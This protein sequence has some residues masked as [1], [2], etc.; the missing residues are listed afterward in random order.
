MREH[1]IGDP[2]LQDLFETTQTNWGVDSGEDG[3]T[4]LN[5]TLTPSP[6]RETVCPGCGKTVITESRN[7]RHDFP[8][9]G[10]AVVF[11]GAEYSQVEGC[12]FEDP[13]VDNNG[14][15][16]EVNNG[17]DT[18]R[19]RMLEKCYANCYFP[20]SSHADIIGQTLNFVASR[21]REHKIVKQ[22][23]SIEHLKN[24]LQ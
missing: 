16:A 7:F 15:L 6:V 19:T 4:V 17:L 1:K 8:S 20:L 12:P 23:P 13:N 14:L 24:V 5:L 22:G 11:N 2:K 9:A 21:I 10:V 18:P 3:T